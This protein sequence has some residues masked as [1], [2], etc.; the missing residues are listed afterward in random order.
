MKI[1]DVYNL[2]AFQAFKDSGAAF[3]DSGFA[4]TVL[5]RNLE[6]IDPTI[7][8]KQFPELA[9]IGSGIVVDNTGG[10]AEKIRSRRTRPVGTFRNAG[11]A[12]DNKGK[13]TIA[14]E[15]QFI[16][17]IE[18]EAESDW[19]DTQIKQAELE[20]IN[21]PQEFIAAHNDIYMREIDEAGLVGINGNKGLFNY[22]GFASSAAAGDAASLTPAQLYEAIAELI[23]DQATAVNNT[24]NYKAGLVLL[25]VS[26]MN[27]ANK[28]ILDSSGGY[29]IGSVMKALRENFPEID[30]KDSFRGNNG[31]DGTVSST[32]AISTSRESMLMRIPETLR[33]GEIVKLGSFHF[34]TDSKYRVAGIDVLEDSAGRIL[35]GL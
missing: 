26:V 10:Y 7:F 29:G 6:A 5:A 30:F 3:K 35:T 12:S 2:K 16:N 24:V 28:K 8:K 32:V 9:L 15:T 18:R 25:P 14:G 17:V 31:F 34:H 11:D 23:T 20:G 13:I 1:G 4:G 21:L 33:I 27:I 22:P 19:T